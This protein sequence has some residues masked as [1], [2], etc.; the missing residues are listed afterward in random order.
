ME[1]ADFKFGI[2]RDTLTEEGNVL[3]VME[4]C[5][6]AGVSRSGYYTWLQAEQTRRAREAQDRADFQVVLA[7]YRFRGYDKGARYSY[8]ASAYGRSDECEKDP[9]AH[10]EIQPFLPDPKSKSVPQ[11]AKSDTDE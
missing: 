6:I 9:A 1:S 8:A 7:A 10:G 2:I 4:L 3:T 11:D 5:D